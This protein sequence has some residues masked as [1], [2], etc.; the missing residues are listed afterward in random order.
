MRMG[1]PTG[2]VFEFDTPLTKPIL[3]WSIKLAVTSAEKVR[4]LTG[5]WVLYSAVMELL[6]ANTA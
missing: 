1:L 5:V 3:F 4:F 6:Q 2:K